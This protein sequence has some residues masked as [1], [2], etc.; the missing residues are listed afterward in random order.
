MT[1]VAAALADELR[2]ALGAA[3]VR[4]GATELGLYR[5]DASNMRGDAA[6]VN[7]L[8]DEELAALP[9]G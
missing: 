3:H 2:S 1:M 9:K 7:R 6:V 4:T 8:L 5:R